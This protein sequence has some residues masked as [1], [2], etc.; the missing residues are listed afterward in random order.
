MTLLENAQYSMLNFQF[1]SE[2]FLERSR[3]VCAILQIAPDYAR[4][5]AHISHYKK[6]ILSIQKH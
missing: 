6:N 1:S 5:S 3:E 4:A 2:G